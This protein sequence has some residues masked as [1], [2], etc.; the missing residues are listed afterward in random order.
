MRLLAANQLTVELNGIIILKNI[1]LEIEEGDRTALLGE[2]G[3]GK[4]T[5]LKALHG[6]IPITEGSISWGVK[7]EEIGWM[8]DEEADG[9][10]NV[11]QYIQKGQPRLSSL[12]E[13]LD[14]CQKVWQEHQHSQEFVEGY[15]NMLQSY[16]EMGGY[17]WE[18]DIERALK[19]VGIPEGL[20]K[21][22]FNRLSG[23]QKTRVKLADLT[24]KK[25]KLLILD[26]PTNHLDSASVDW[27]ADWLSSYKGTV[28]FISHE[29]DFIDRTASV[30]YELTKN[31][32]KRYQGGYSRYKELR[33]EERKAHAALY[34]KQKQEKKKLLEII[35]NYKQWYQKASNFASVRN[36]Y[37]QKQAGRQAAKVKAKEKQL[38]RLESRRVDK[39]QAA[40]GIKAAFS[41]DAIDSKRIVALEGVSFSYNEGTPLYENMNLSISRGERIAV[42]GPNGAGKTTLLKL[43]TGKLS[44][45]SG[46]VKRNPQ[47]K[48]G[49]FMQELE[50]LGLENTILQEILQIKEI[51]EED[52]RTILACFL[53]RRDDVYKKIRDLSMGEKCRVAFVKLYFSDSNLLILD[54]PAN[55]LDISA[56]E[57]IETALLSYDGSVVIVSHDPYMLRKVSTRVISVTPG[58]VLDFKGTYPEWENHEARDSDGQAAVNQRLQ[59]ELKLG[60]LLNGETADLEQIKSIRKKIDELK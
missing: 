39:P 11:L 22:S 6:K 56:R 44:P 38:E 19:E 31:G 53:F 26:E 7:K 42:I 21:E 15:T 30:T 9:S 23:G 10:L 4:T 54:E 58:K 27:L 34:E 46:A 59:L 41:S 25:P 35:Q 55:Y 32:A 50:E 28:L 16:T 18:L 24:V 12:K 20:W 60:D 49:Y 29:R 36:P 48:T 33:D 47:L 8:M 37:A 43:L 51:T 5:L 3:A 2:N 52:A 57:Q 1:S 45:D 17:E 14:E 40:R 13:K